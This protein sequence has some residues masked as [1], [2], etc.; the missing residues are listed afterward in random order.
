MWLFPCAFVCNVHVYPQLG[1]INFAGCGSCYCWN[2]ACFHHKSELIVKERV[3]I[4]FLK[5]QCARFR[6]VYPVYI[7]LLPD[8]RHKGTLS[9]GELF[10][11][12]RLFYVSVRALVPS[13]FLVNT[14]GC[15]ASRKRRYSGHVYI[16]VGDYHVVGSVQWG[17]SHLY[18]EV[19]L[20]V[21]PAP[22]LPSDRLSLSLFRFLSNSLS[23]W[24][25]QT[26]PNS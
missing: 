7:M 22:R 15:M 16:G 19:S 26:L 5:I 12:K 17:R 14:K 8:L 24:V 13:H 2:N 21:L 23:N 4:L 11:C 18:K 25:C 3:N 20:F 1:K 6:V 10:E 9:V